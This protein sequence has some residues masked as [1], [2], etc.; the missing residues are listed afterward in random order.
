LQSRIVAT[1]KQ[2]PSLMTTPDPAL[3]VD[4]YNRTASWL[5]ARAEEYATGQARHIVLMD[6]QS[7]DRSAE[8]AEELRH[9]AGNLAA[10]VVAFERL[11][12]KP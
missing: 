7:V 5:Q 6:G 4:N 3:F 10:T 12:A 11:S 9:L 8:M 1:G 2:H